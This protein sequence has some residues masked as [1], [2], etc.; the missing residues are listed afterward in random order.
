M[1]VLSPLWTQRRWQRGKT[2]QR[3]AVIQFGPSGGTDIPPATSLLPC[4]P[5]CQHRCKIPKP[6]KIVILHLWVFASAAQEREAG[7][8]NQGGAVSQLENDM[9]REVSYLWRPHN[10]RRSLLSTGEGEFGSYGPV[11]P[12]FKRSLSAWGRTR[13]QRGHPSS[14]SPVRSPGWWKASLTYN[15]NMRG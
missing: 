7:V 2:Q 3:H 6:P 9:P 14:P 11:L 10:H 5:V 13:G 8:Q 1:E 12:S 4:F 15:V